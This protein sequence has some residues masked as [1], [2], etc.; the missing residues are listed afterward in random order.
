MKY[1][2]GFDRTQTSLFPSCIDELIPDDAEVRAVDIFVDSLPLRALG[3]LD[4][5][6]VEEGRPMYHP[7]DLFKLYVYGYLNRIRTSR[8]LERE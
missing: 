5:E 8:L 2:E 4:H 3:F 7:R 1:L 6:P